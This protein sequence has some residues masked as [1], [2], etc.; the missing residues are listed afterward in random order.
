MAEKR[1]ILVLDLSNDHDVHGSFLW[2][3]CDLLVEVHSNGHGAVTQHMHTLGQYLHVPAPGHL[4]EV[5]LLLQ[6]F[7]HLVV[8]HA[9]TPQPGFDGVVRLGKHYKFGHV[10]YTDNFSIHL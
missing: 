7:V 8:S 4:G 10:R 2:L 5:L 6:G 1:L 3:F 9:E